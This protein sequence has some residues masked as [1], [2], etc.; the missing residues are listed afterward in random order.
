[1]VQAG[2]FP[3]SDRPLAFAMSVA[4]ARQEAQGCEAQGSRRA[5]DSGSSASAG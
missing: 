3:T 1:M 2:N 4:A 5:R